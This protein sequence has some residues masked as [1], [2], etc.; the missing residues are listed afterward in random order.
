MLF[1]RFGSLILVTILLIG[2]VTANELINIDSLSGPSSI[3]SVDTS[4]RIL[5]PSSFST[6]AI[7][8]DSSPWLSS[9]SPGHDPEVLLSDSTNQ[10]ACPQSRKLR[11]SRRDGAG[12]GAEVC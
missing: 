10:K 12:G 8:G 6:E 7:L 9:S 4:N 1:Q 5:D 3:P 11:K 2:F